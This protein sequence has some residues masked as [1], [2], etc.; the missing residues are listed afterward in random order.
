[1]I[2]E[3]FLHHVEENT[4][5]VQDAHKGIV[6]VGGGVVG[7]EMASEL[8]LLNKDAKITLAHSRQ[9]LLSSEPLPDET[10]EE[11]LE[12]LRE[13]GVT[14]LLNHS[15]DSTDVHTTTQG[16]CDITV[17]FTNG[18]KMLASMVFVAISRSNPST[19]YLPYSAVD[20]NGYVKVQPRSAIIIIL[21]VQNLILLS[22]NLKPDI[23]N[24]AYH[25]SAG[26]INQSS[27]I[28]R[29]GDAM[30]SGQIIAQT[31]INRFY[32]STMKLMQSFE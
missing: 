19:D 8:K 23:P 20:S 12:L 17:K 3:Q 31:F 15:L 24:H 11:A 25:Y 14:V 5:Q 29:C 1:M 28:K 26:D 7:L 2:R 6:V 10:K 32:N 30:H 21:S 9:N 18:H 27:G 22:L 16:N 4:R 13:A